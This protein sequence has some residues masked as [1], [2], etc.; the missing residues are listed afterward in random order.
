MKYLIKLIR[1]VLE[2]VA[3]LKNIS[4]EELATI[5]YENSLKVFNL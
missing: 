4:E 5:A 1:H 3:K 2:A